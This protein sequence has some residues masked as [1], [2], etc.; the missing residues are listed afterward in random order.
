VFDKEPLPSDSEWRKFG[1]N[2][3]L[4]PHVGYVEPPAYEGFYSGAVDTAL[5]WLERR[6]DDI[7]KLSPG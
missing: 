5:A 2:V 3:I 1:D 4:S 6:Y 7:I